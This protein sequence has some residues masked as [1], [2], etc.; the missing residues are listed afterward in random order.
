MVRVERECI[1]FAARRT[2]HRLQRETELEAVVEFTQ[3]SLCPWL[4]SKFMYSSSKQSQQGNLCAGV[5]LVRY[6]VN[7]AANE[8]YEVMKQRGNP[9]VTAVRDL[10]IASVVKV[11]QHN[12]LTLQVPSPHAESLIRRVTLSR[13][14][15]I[16]LFCGIQ[17][18]PSS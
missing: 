16:L 1:W 10:G 6:I 3:R 2:R 8:Q 14:Q 18:A 4:G 15:K 12:I 11:L 9:V 13:K 5:R 7:A 17:H